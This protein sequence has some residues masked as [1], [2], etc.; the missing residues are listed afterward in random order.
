MFSSSIRGTPG[1]LPS[2]GD[3]FQRYRAL[4]ADEQTMQLLNPIEL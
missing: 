3:F 2:L 4:V 1:A